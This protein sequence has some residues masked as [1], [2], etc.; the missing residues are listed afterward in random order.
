MT[1]KLIGKT[2]KID[3]MN[4]FDYDLK[5]CDCML[6][7]PLMDKDSV[8]AT[9]TDIP[10]GKCSRK[11]NG[12]RKL[13]YG[14]ADIETFDLPMFLT[15][16]CRV[17]KGSIYIFCSTEQVSEI[18][19]YLDTHGW[20]TRLVIWEKSNPSPMNGNYIWLSGVE[21]CVY[22]KSKGATFNEH[23]VNP[24]FRYPTVRKK[25]HPTEKPLKLI[26]RLIQAS[27]NK[28]DLVFDPCAGS[29]TTAVACHNLDRRF[30]GCE[31]DKQYFDIAIQKI[32]DSLS[33]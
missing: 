32:K 22:G 33:N 12:L 19:K 27:T 11:S 26:E 1:T 30:I 2:I 31:L 29:G 23:C 10:Y 28:G 7:M 17:T 4:N 8:A 9:I 14:K 3:N 21:C 25:A 6:L 16:I 13:D 24:V 15:E 5:N 18:R 20:S